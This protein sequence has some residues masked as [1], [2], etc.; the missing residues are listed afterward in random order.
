MKK[1]IRNLFLI[2]VVGGIAYSNSFSVPFQFDDIFNIVDNPVI[3]NI[4]NF[5]SSS[6]GYDYN[7]RRYI[8]YLSLAMNYRA[9]G[10]AVSGYH[11][12]NLAVHII[13]AGLVY[14]LILLTFRTPYF[15]G[16]E[17][18]GMRNRENWTE[19]GRPAFQSL[20]ALFSALLFVAHPLQ[21]QAVTYI[22]QRF[23]SLAATFYLLSVVMYVKGRLS[24][25]KTR[26]TTYYI[27]SLLF[28]VI[29][30]KTKEIA[31]TLPVIILMYEFFFFRSGLKKKLLFLLPVLLT[32]VIIPVSI[33]GA[34]KPLGEILSDLS[35]KTRVQT[36]ISRWDYLM[37][38]TRVVT[39][40]IR[41]IF[42]P[43]NQNLD[44][45]Y[46]ISHSLSSPHVLLS[47]FFLMSI[48]GCAVYL[49][50]KAA[51]GRR[52]AVGNNGSASR[53]GRGATVET[54]E[55]NI[56]P[57]GACGEFPITGY[58]RLIAFG[59]FWFFITLSVESSIIPIADVIFE[60]RV[61]LPSAGAF[62]AIT[63]SVFVGARMLKGNRK[64][65]E[66]I[67][68]A[69]FA[70]AIVLLTGATFLRNRVWQS[71]T[72]L[73]EDVVQKS[74]ENARAYNNLGY[75]MMEK[76]QS[77]KAAGY[78]A[79]ALQLRPGYADARN[80]LG[81]AYYN[82]G[83]MDAAIAQFKAVESEVSSGPYAADARHNLGLAYIQKGMLDEAITEMTAAL[84]LTPGSAEIYN[85]LGMAYKK[86]GLPNEATGC[87]EKAVRLR[88]DYA[89]AHFN[90]G[91]M[92]NERGLKEEAER[93]LRKAHDLDPA[94]F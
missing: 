15:A 88:P 49:L 31:F 63:A 38:E 40:Y 55:G 73:W 3:H 92:Y 65:T 28:A 71:E 19:D 70:L 51:A 46:P 81:V 18:C 43:V 13:N 5:I 91:L 47:F 10:L 20:I 66:R 25:R 62:V 8:G 50:H 22:V 48:F 39:T 42:L 69:T 45:D 44:Y 6:K 78:F 89:G 54:L 52:N 68:I 93:H 26:M 41:L 84:A 64:R 82:L 57:P 56:P 59:I 17:E 34:H 33:M 90:L 86:K 79:R 11:A 72:G 29:A 74:P 30:M 9:G 85:D 16:D 32:L 14:F 24:D 80:N 67:V 75:L 83:Y 35:E 76:G 36:N 37:T 7:P 12:V 77:E 2:A 61:Y 27:L 23:T 21:T 4:N 60:H 53:S 58:Y 94:R 1:T 87:F